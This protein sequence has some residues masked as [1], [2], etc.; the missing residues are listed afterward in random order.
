MEIEKKKG[1]GPDATF[2]CV[3]DSLFR[4][5]TPADIAHVAS[6]KKTR[7]KLPKCY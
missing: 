1:L 2:E 5:P 4:A 6:K 3:F 7:T